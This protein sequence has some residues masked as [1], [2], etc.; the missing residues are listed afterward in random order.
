MQTGTEWWLGKLKEVK[1]H[2]ARDRR[3]IE[4]EGLEFTGKFPHLRP[5]VTAMAIQG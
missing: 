5:T 4:P 3:L 1:P 2:P